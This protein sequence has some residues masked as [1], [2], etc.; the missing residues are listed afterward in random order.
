MKRRPLA[1]CRLLLVA[2][3]AL[4]LPLAAAAQPVPG[5][6][7]AYTPGAM[8][9]CGP[10]ADGPMPPHPGDGRGPG[11]GFG[12][13]DGGMPPPPMLHGLALT[14]AQRD[15]VFAIVHA[16]A[17]VAREKAKSAR[18]AQE[19]LRALAMSAQYD[20][21]KAR[22]LA[23]AAAAALADLAFLHA[24]GHHQ[25]YLVLTDEQR[26]QLTTANAPGRRP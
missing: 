1:F 24:D 10:A 15:K 12:G 17:P 7:A 20:A 19:E 4:A 16:Q 13:P 14:E 11:H 3:A 6:L 26:Q 5:D 22:T 25:I 9:F 2:A 18:R 21:A 8:P 23:D